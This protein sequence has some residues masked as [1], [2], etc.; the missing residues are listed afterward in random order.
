MKLCPDSMEE[1]KQQLAGLREH[2]GRV[3]G[4]DMRAMD[5]VLAYEPADMTVTVEAGITLAR[6]QAHVGASG[7]WLPVDPPHADR[8]TVGAMIARNASGSRRYGYGTIRE[9]LLGVGVVLA[10][11]RLIRSGGRV[12]KNVAGYDLQKLFVG[13]HGSLGVIVEATFKLTPL[14]EREAW[15]QA[16]CQTLDEAGRLL[17]RVVEERIS[18]V[19][20][21]L[22]NLSLSVGQGGC[23]MVLGFAGVREQVEREVQRAGSMGIRG[24][25]AGDEVLRFWNGETA[26]RRVSVR[27]S[28]T[29]ETLRAMGGA[30]WLAHAGNGVIHYRGGSGAVSRPV[31]PWTLVRRIKAAFD[32]MQILPDLP[33]EGTA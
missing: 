28:A 24:A 23:T 13:S 7:Q 26:P 30:S 5:R 20:L 9:H 6:L 25:V 27:P 14:P 19:A 4:V 8:C 11:G 17:E 21:D 15:V 18:C 1:L 16:D 22:H 2:G 33:G 32:P 31:V 3:E 29:V 10:D 12:V